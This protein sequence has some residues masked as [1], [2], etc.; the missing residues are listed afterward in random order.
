M[1][2]QPIL[3][4][5]AVVTAT[6]TFPV[7]NIENAEKVTLMFTR[8]NHSA[9]STEFT[10]EGSIDGTTYVALNTIVDNV[11]NT[12]S[13]TLTRVASVSLASNTSKL[14]ALDLE[15]FNYKLIRVTAT[16]TTDGS[17]SYKA[18]IEFC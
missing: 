3:I 11:T 18:L 6:T 7:V 8:A 1:R 16:E 12:N 2:V 5:S 9:G 14:Y 4:E 10:V 15:N 13:Q 17:H